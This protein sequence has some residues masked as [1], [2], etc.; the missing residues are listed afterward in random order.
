MR[1]HIQVTGTVLATIAMLAAPWAAPSA[2]LAKNETETAKKHAWLGVVTQAVDDDLREGLNLKDD[3][4]LVNSVADE[5]PAAK[6]GIRVGDVIVS[7]NGAPVDSPEALQDAVRAANAGAKVQVEI[8]RDTKRQTIPVTLGERPDRMSW[9]DD[10]HRIVIREAP[11]ARMDMPGLPDLAQ[12]GDMPL[13]GRGRLGVELD[14][15]NP[16]L[17]EYFSVP[18]G[19]GAL[20]T[21]VVKDSPAARAGFKAG[22]VI[23]KVGDREV[24][25]SESTARA[26]RSIDGK[27]AIGVMRK[28]QRM[29]LNAELEGRHAPRAMRDESGMDRDELPMQI[30]V[31]ERHQHE[32]MQMRRE[33]EQLRE[34]IR[35]LREQLRQKSQN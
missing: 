25:D 28:G 5:S 29:T 17:G 3:G 8:V 6:A 22:D 20:V 18:G 15:L 12:L 1:S 34:E 23:V 35:A 21:S 9:G 30:H 33:M 13:F 4:V 24:E 16:D 19:K 10:R 26:I 14:D 32:R 2:A 7:L 27:V 31:M 11:E